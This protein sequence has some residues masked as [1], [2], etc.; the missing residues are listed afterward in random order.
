M[1]SMGRP[2]S[3]KSRHINIRYYHAK[4]LVENGDITFEYCAT[5]N[6]RADILTKP[7]SGEQFRKLSRW[8]LN[9]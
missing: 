4:E 3:F 7:L 2:T 5:E 1:I 8:L 9:E 6:M